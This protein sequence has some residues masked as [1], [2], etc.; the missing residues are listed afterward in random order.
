MAGPTGMLSVSGGP[1]EM[2][3]TREYQEWIERARLRAGSFSAVTWA[4][5]LGQLVRHLFV[6]LQGWDGLAGPGL[7]VGVVATLGI[8]LEQIDRILVRRLLVRHVLF[9]EVRAVEI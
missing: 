9:V 5:L 7:Q 4:A 8:A 2:S 6:M 1:R 3:G